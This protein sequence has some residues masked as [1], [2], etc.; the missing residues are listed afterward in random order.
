MKYPD[1]K[2]LSDELLKEQIAIG[3]YE[4]GFNPNLTLFIDEE[5]FSYGYGEMNGWIGIWE[6]H[7]PFWYSK[8]YIEKN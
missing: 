4:L 5:S 2:F 3:L 6:Y 1:F 7:I 8:K